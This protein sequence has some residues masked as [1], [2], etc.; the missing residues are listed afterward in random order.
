M[1]RIVHGRFWSDFERIKGSRVGLHIAVKDK[2]RKTGS[3]ESYLM[4][5]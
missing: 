5:S 1:R 2:S 4:S 3:D